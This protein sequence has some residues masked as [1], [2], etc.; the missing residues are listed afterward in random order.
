V[1]F[2]ILEHL[3][4]LSATMD[5]CY[6]ILAPGGRLLIRGPMVGKVHQ[7]ADPTHFRAFTTDSFDFWCPATER[8]QTRAY[9]CGAGWRKASAHEVGN[10]VEIVLE[11]LL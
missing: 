5:E 10:N 8:G 3:I 11:K 4:D 7:F 6:R 2:D 9:Y 1:A